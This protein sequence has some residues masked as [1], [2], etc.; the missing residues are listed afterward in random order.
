VTAKKT[1]TLSNSSQVSILHQIIIIVIFT[2]FQPFK[3]NILHFEVILVLAKIFFTKLFILHF[4]N[5]HVRKNEKLRLDILN[6]FAITTLFISNTK[7]SKSKEQE[8]E[9]SKRIFLM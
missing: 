6:S 2:N 8:N 7:K 9:R 1:I 3:D 4:E 5:V